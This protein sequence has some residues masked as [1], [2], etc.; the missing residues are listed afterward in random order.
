MIAEACLLFALSGKLSCSGP[1]MTSKA[2]ALAEQLGAGNIRLK[3]QPHR[4]LGILGGGAFRLSCGGFV[5]LSVTDPSQLPPI[6]IT[7]TSHDQI[8]EQA[9]KAVYT[10]PGSLQIP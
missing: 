8:W 3:C 9:A 6:A 4:G 10:L 7:V 1:M 2:Q 5:I